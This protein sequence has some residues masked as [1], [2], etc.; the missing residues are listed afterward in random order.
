MKARNEQRSGEEKERLERRENREIEKGRTRMGRLETRRNRE[1]EKTVRQKNSGR[2][3]ETQETR[4]SGERIRK[5][6]M[7]GSGKRRKGEIEKKKTTGSWIRKSGTKMRKWNK[8]RDQ[9][10]VQTWTPAFRQ[11]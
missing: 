11:R 8:R 5:P 10:K 3:I 6:E 4:G 1:R 2:G 7:R 9:G